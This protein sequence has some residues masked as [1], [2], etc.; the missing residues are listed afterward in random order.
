[1]SQKIRIPSKRQLQVA[2]LIKK[3]L[4]EVFNSGRLFIP[5]LE[6][7]S[8]TVSEVQVNADLK[9]AFIYVLPLN[10]ALAR[11]VFM[12]LIQEHE[13]QIRFEVTQLIRLKFSPKMIFRFDDSFDRVEHFEKIFESMKHTPE[14]QHD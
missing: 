8:I 3:A 1:M 12:S 4:V 2:E 5:G 10:K 9:T 11:D 13:K 7:S 6:D 14:T